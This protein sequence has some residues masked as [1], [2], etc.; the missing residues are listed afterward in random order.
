[1]FLWTLLVLLVGGYVLLV[2]VLAATQRDIIYHPSKQTAEPADAG[3]DEMVPVPVRAADGVV[4]TGWYAPPGNPQR[5][6]VVLFHGNGGA[7]VHRARKARHFLNLGYGMFLAEY[8]GYGANPGRPSED[9]LY[10]DAR[11]V[12]TWLAARGVPGSR[13]VLYG[14]SLGSGVAV[15]MATEHE[16]AALVLEAPFTRLPALAPPYI[17]EPLA[18][19]LMAD[20]YDNLAKIGSLAV[21]VLV[22]HGEDDIVVPVGMGRALLAAAASSPV[23]EGVFP[24]MAGHHNI[25]EL[26]AEAA[27]PDFLQRT[28]H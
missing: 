16:V 17:P 6:T 2:V 4:V 7:I 9:G 23:A 14:E 12:L 10:A 28:V 20:R 18:E 5:P 11:A 8:R 21:P 24:P 13:L 27:V 15:Q 3:L 22:A 1:M 19:V 25:W 26:A